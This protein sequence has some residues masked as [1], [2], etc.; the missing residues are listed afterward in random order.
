MAHHS[1]SP[2]PTNPPRLFI[3]SSLDAFIIVQ[4]A[5]DGVFPLCTRSLTDEEREKLQYHGSVVVWDETAVANDPGNKCKGK[6]RWKYT[7]PWTPSR[8]QGVFLLYRQVLPRKGSKADHAPPP[9]HEP[10]QEVDEVFGAHKG[11]KEHPVGGLMRK[12]LSLVVDNREL[13][14]INYYDPYKQLEESTRLPSPSS[15][16]PYCRYKYNLHPDIIQHPHRVLSSTF[17][18]NVLGAD[19]PKLIYAGDDRTSQRDL[20]TRREELEAFLKLTLELA[21]ENFSID[22]TPAPKREHVTASMKRPRDESDDDDFGGTSGRPGRKKARHPL[23]APEEKMKVKRVK[24]NEYTDSPS[25]SA[26]D[27]G[28]DFR[29]S[30]GVPSRNASQ[31][32]TLAHRPSLST[33]VSPTPLR[34][35]PSVLNP[36]PLPRHSPGIRQHGI[37]G[38]LVSD[39]GL[40]QIS[41]RPALAYPPPPYASL[42][43]SSMPYGV[44]VVGPAHISP[45]SSRHYAPSAHS[46]YPLVS[47]PT[48]HIVQPHL[49][50][51]PS[52]INGFK[53]SAD[54]QSFGTLNGHLDAEAPPSPIENAFPPMPKP[55]EIAITTAPLSLPDEYSPSGSSGGY[56]SNASGYP[57]PHPHH[58]PTTLGTVHIL[59]APLVAN[60]GPSLK[61]G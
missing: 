19:K 49:W 36:T 15:S 46:P 54:H 21:P 61:D 38:G 32:P 53:A 12:T 57:T 17:T 43:A 8:M 33:P 22:F 40:A 3:R 7:T 41:Q 42:P 27:D 20:K 34:I 13:H 16:H 25:S 29:P 6:Q 45:P 37:T 58:Y 60:M 52:F 1:P 35:G 10:K 56:T 48:A 28:S 14:L 11:Y 59:R 5:L 24:E 9:P 2:A 44:P 55:L 18:V 4:S 39:A 47:Y 23:G 51:H 31:P 30:T 26:G 50:A